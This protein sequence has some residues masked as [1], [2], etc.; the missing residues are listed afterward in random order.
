M[1]R[2][3]FLRTAGTTA[4]LTPLV[5]N[6]FSI[7]PLSSNS[8][9]SQIAASA[10]INGRVM[11]FIELA[12]GNDGINTLIP[13]DQYASLAN[14][15][16]H[17]LIPEN[18][19]LQLDGTNATGLHPSMTGLQQLYNEGLMSIVQNVG[20]PQQDYSHFRSMDIWM[21]GS[22]SNEYLG[23]GWLGRTLE[24]EY[25][26]FPQGYPNAD[27]PDP[28]AIQI[29]SITPIAFMGTSYPM[30]MAI[31]SAD[32]FYDFVNDFTEPAPA[33][34]Y[35]DE[36]E[37]I[38]LVMNQ[39]Q[40]YYESLKTAAENSFN[41]SNKYPETNLANQLRIVAR[42]INGGLQTPV[43]VVSLGGF[44]TH[45]EQVDPMDVDPSVGFHAALL[46]NL[47]DSIYA[48]Q[49]DLQL[50]GVDDK[51]CGMT[52]SEF[53]R[54]IG[55]NGSFGTDH[56]AAAPL[57]VFGKN[58]NPGL[59]GDNPEIPTVIQSSQDLP[60]VHDFRQVYASVL[61]DWFGIEDWQGI[62]QDSFDILPI[63]K[64]ATPTDEAIGQGSSDPFQVTN[65]PNPV[66]TSTTIAFSSPGAF[67]TINLMDAQGRHILKIA[68]GQY[69]VGFHR[70]VFDR[71]SLNSG[72]YFY[73]V[74]LNGIAVT[75][76]MLVL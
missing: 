75:K 34:Y 14:H 12:G 18:K 58:V 70:I 51:V 25:P 20:Y 60:M 63:F 47:S 59:I 1:K 28:L 57:M 41:L 33:G 67:V 43:Y 4:A 23:T 35:G 11:V 48:F 31:S 72:T 21:T 10:T 55:E 24:G 62:L 9:F 52:F 17:L 64:G 61:Q 65:Y 40:Q 53:G 71:S 3:N 36:L 46:K 7:N 69:P 19:V 6:G 22:D 30:G 44:D 15:R 38:R 56:G 54:T 76:K 2:R 16:S 42:L 74:K 73:Q 32:E 66:S 68:E 39:S 49:D 29:G 5:Y 50:M 8:V 45:S 13:L 27:F 37:Y 26:G